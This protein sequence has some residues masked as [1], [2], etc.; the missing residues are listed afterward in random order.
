MSQL[1]AEQILAGKQEALC[2]QVQCNRVT[3]QCAGGLALT[4]DQPWKSGV[5][6]IWRQGSKPGGRTP[7]H[8]SNVTRKMSSF[9]KWK[10]IA[11]LLLC[12]M[13]I[14]LDNNKWNR[15]IL[16]QSWSPWTVACQAPLSMGFSRQKYWSGLPCPPLGDLPNPEIEPVSLMM[17]P[18]LAGESFVTSIISFNLCFSDVFLMIR[19]RFC[20]FETCTTEMVNSS[21]CIASRNT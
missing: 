19:L 3:W 14:K 12:V 2:V 17:F 13:K 11:I 4:R 7:P 5:S 9:V 1:I 16:Y 10:V 18:T 21:Q 20:I 8:R 6:G 15:N